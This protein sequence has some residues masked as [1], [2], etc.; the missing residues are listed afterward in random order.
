MSEIISCESLKNLPSIAERMIQKYPEKRIFAFFG[1]M[2]AGKTTFIKEVC[3][4]I[5]VQDVV[6]SPTFAIINVYETLSGENVNH[7][8]FYRIKNEQEVLD[9]GYEDYFY[10]QNYCLIEWPEKVENYLPEDTV[11]VRIKKNEE[12]GFREFEF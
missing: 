11:V 8:D 4:H 2:G 6:N 5:G 7:F 10:S 12:T 3:Q 1:T 9:L